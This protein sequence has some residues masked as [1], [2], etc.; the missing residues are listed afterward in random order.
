MIGLRTFLKDF[1]GYCDD[2][3]FDALY[4]RQR[5]LVRCGLL[6]V[7]GGRG[8]GSGVPLTS[9]TLATFLIALLVTESLKEVGELTTVLSGARPL[10]AGSKSGVVRS[11]TRT[12]HGDVS[13]ALTGAKIA[14]FASSRDLKKTLTGGLQVTRHWR[15]VL[16]QDI[17]LENGNR[18]TRTEGVQGIEYTV[19]VGARL[20]API[21]SITSSIEGEPW[22]Y[23]CERFQ[24]VFE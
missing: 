3:S 7:I 18:K 21:I 17:E 11:N 22:W 2:G 23:L 4:E 1:A 9:D 20:A 13:K 19:G 8:P 6:P 16:L 24:Q 5:E 10:I 15:G 12:F 14:G